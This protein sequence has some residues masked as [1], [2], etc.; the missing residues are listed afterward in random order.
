MEINNV[1]RE[2][3]VELHLEHEERCLFRKAATADGIEPPF[4]RFK[5]EYSPD[6]LIALGEMLLT[7][8]RLDV[9]SGDERYVAGEYGHR[10]KE[11]AFDVTK[12]TR[13]SE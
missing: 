12:P 7:A 8:N 3:S 1:R 10:L 5:D 11:I 4:E 2:I 9:F 6:D 13:F